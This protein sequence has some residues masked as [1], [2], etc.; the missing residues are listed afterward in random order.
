[1]IPDN[2]NGNGMDDNVPQHTKPPSTTLH[3]PH[4]LIQ[5]F[6]CISEKARGEGEG[7]GKEAWQTM[8]KVVACNEKP[9]A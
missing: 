6:F 4:D 8:L 1:M 5:H 9:A 3:H 2:G 7:G